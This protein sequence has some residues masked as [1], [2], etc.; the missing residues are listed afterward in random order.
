VLIAQQEA[1][2]RERRIFAI[3]LIGVV[4]GLVVR[5]N[6][7]DVFGR[8]VLKYMALTQILILIDHSGTGD[9]CIEV[10]RFWQVSSCRGVLKL[11]LAGIVIG[12]LTVVG[13]TS[14]RLRTN[15]FL[16]DGERQSKDPDSHISHNEG[17]GVLVNVQ[18]AEARG[19]ISY[20]TIGIQRP[21]DHCCS[22][23][24]A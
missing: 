16:M 9:E 12:Y 5:A 21:M 6:P 23:C 22:C 17:D 14:S 19:A 11:G 7:L 15:L 8:R 13:A 3:Y 18:D 24:Y 10:T 1:A 20:S 2:R 4:A